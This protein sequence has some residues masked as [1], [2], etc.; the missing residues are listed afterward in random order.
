LELTESDTLK[1]SS[2]KVK[3]RRNKDEKSVEIK[4]RQ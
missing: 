3:G 1:E 2:K 4:E